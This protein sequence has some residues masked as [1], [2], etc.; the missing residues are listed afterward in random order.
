MPALY[1]QMSHVVKDDRLDLSSVRRRSDLSESTQAILSIVCNYL[2]SGFPVVASTSEHTVTLIGWRRTEAP[3][4]EIELV[5]SD[6]DEIFGTVYASQ[7]EEEKWQHLM[8][9]LPP[10]VV[11][12]GETAQAEAYRALEKLKDFLIDSDG[13][14]IKSL[15]QTRIEEIETLLEQEQISLR[16]QLKRRHDYRSAVRG[17]VDSRGAEVGN[18]LAV[19]RLPGWVWVVEV[20]DRE[21]RESGED[22][23]VAEF[24]FD[25][26]SPDDAPQPAAVSVGGLVWCNWPYDSRSIPARTVAGSLNGSSPAFRWSSQINSAMALDVPDAALQVAGRHH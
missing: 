12:T 1:Y 9:P 8:I 21:A 7:L 16:L 2:N 5:Y 23:V 13:P 15:A 18:A 22:C 6:A 11:L 19:L 14:E 4:G 20:Q 10:D 24:V 3:D 26:T 17:Q 25:T